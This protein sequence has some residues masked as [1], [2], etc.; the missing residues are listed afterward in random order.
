MMQPIEDGIEKCYSS[1]TG[2]TADD[3]IQVTYLMGAL[4]LA[5]HCGPLHNESH[6]Y[7]PSVKRMQ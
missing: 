2:V 3:G 5:I 6:L 1:L 4:Q 7:T